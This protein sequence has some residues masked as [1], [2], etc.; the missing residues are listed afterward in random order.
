VHI[1]EQ[2]R[3]QFEGVINV[4]RFNWPTYMVALVAVALAGSIAVL[5]ATTVVL[6]VF[7]T[8]FCAATGFFA[9][10][11]LVVSHL[12]YDRSRL[13]RWHWLSDRFK[14]PP[15]KIINAHAGFD[16]TSNALHAVFPQSEL[17]AVD[18]FREDAKSESSIIRARQ[19]S[20]SKYPATAVGLEQWDWPEQSIDLVVLCFAAHELRVAKDREKL[21]NE[22]ARIVRPDGLV[23]VVEHLR[24][25]PN[26]AAFGPGFMHFLPYS[27][28]LQCIQAGGLQV[29]DEFKITPF[30]KVWCLCRT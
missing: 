22:L 16:E 27:E 23:V 29:Q 11:S 19:L 13:Y 25:L 28:W 18:F 20:H 6:R 14:Q 9:V 10:S 2:P 26:F 12:V 17:L 5:P 24:D 21:F 3:K 30:V 7:L 4:L 15:T 8:A 1:S